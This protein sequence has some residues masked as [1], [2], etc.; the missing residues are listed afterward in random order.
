[1]SGIS[2]SHSALLDADICVG[3]FWITPERL[4]LG[5][6]FLYPFD[7]DNMYLVARNDEEEGA[8]TLIEILKKP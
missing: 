6:E 2:S 1:M 4:A 8:Q 7:T 5:V 3:D